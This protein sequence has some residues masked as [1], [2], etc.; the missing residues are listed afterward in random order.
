[1]YGLTGVVLD[2]A[3]GGYAVGQYGLVVERTAAGWADAG[4]DLSIQL[5]LHGVW[6]SPSGGV[7]AVGGQTASVPLVNG[8][9]IHRGEAIPQGGL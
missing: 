5:D 8:L 4:T 2:E 3:D 7:W 6:M 1:V 9:L